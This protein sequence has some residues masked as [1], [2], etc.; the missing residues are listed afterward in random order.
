MPVCV[1]TVYT[2]SRELH[3]NKANA[4]LYI[5]KRAKGAVCEKFVAY[6]FADWFNLILHIHDDYCLSSV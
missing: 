5:R 3:T 2:A 1:C 6:L 4:K